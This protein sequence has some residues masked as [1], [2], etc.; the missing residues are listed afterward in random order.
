MLSVTAYVLRKQVQNGWRWIKDTIWPEKVVYGGASYFCQESYRAGSEELDMSIP[1]FQCTIYTKQGRELVIHGSAVRFEHDYLV[2]PDHVLTASGPPK[3]AKGRQGILELTAGFERVPLGTDMVGIKLTEQQFSLIGL[4]KAKVAYLPDRGIAAA[5][6][7]PRGKGTMSTLRAD[8][9]LFGIVEYQGTTAAGYSGAGYTVGNN[10][11]GVHQ[12][13]GATNGGLN[14]SYIYARILAAEKKKSEATW[15]WLEK[16]DGE[17]GGV[18]YEEYGLDEVMIKTGQNRYDIVSR[19]A[20]VK[21]YGHDYNTERDG[22]LRKKKIR[23]VYDDRVDPYGP[24]PEYHPESGEYRQPSLSG[25]SVVEDE[26]RDL[27]PRQRHYLMERLTRPSRNY[28][29]RYHSQ[30]TGRE[31]QSRTTDGLVASSGQP[32]I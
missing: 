4:S 25:A 26:P 27:T 17:Y 19:D 1:T 23:P 6:V 15:E 21:V 24:E 12:F 13:G 9:R 11:L 7:S 20:V 10:I 30:R 2:A 5:I 29:R 32:A 18:E 31:R 16:L 8:K 3:V 28:R 22:K 14:A